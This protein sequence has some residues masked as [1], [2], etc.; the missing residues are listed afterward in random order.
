MRNIPLE[1]RRLLELAGVK[2][3]DLKNEATTTLLI[4]VMKQHEDVYFEEKPPVPPRRNSSEL[5]PVVQAEQPIVEEKQ[6]MTMWDYMRD[7]KLKPVQHVEK[8][9]EK[10]L[11]DILKEEMDKRRPFIEK[12]E[13]EEE[14]SEWDDYQ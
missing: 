13:A 11:V 12:E 4:D 14:N 10:G 8:V 1:W 9:K 2:P 5:N 6:A 3:K 7:H